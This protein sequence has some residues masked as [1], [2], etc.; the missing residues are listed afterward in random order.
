MRSRD[1]AGS[2]AASQRFGASSKAI[3]EIGVDRRLAGLI[4]TGRLRALSRRLCQPQRTIETAIHIDL[5]V[6]TKVLPDCQHDNAAFVRK[7]D[8]D[9]VTPVDLNRTDVLDALARE[10]VVTGLASF[11]CQPLDRRVERPSRALPRSA[12][13][14]LCP[15]GVMLTR[16]LTRRYEA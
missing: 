1:S 12:S 5:R 11:G 14:L 2:P 3:E 15:V 9:P 16:W 8:Q 6:V 7:A 10:P 4:T 13:T